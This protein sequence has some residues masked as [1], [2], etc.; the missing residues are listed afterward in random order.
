M[1]LKITEEERDGTVFVLV[2]I[3]RVK[4][5]KVQMQRRCGWWIL[6]HHQ[7]GHREVGGHGTSQ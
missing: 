7:N 1:H 5:H 4:N 2:V 3:V 6:W